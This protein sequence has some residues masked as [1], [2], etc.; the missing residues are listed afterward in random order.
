MWST[1]RSE[2]TAVLQSP[3]VGYQ[4]P[5]CDLCPRFPQCSLIVTSDVS[6]LS[7]NRLRC[8]KK[9]QTPVVGL[10]YISSCLQ[11]GALLPVDGY[12]LDASPVPAPTTKSNR[13][14]CS[15]RILRL[16]L[17]VSGRLLQV[18]YL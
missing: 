16:R 13:V 4:S 12:R 9:Y 15:S 5:V 3:E 1:S 11:T 8:I 2:V 10:D 6:S 18:V 17:R 14:C 7:P